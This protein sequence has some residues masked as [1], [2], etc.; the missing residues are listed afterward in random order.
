[1][2]LSPLDILSISIHW[3]LYL[4]LDF[5]RNTQSMHILCLSQLTV[6][7]GHCMRTV[8]LS[9]PL[10]YSADDRKCTHI[11]NSANISVL[12]ALLKLLNMVFFFVFYGAKELLILAWLTWYESSDLI[13]I[14]IVLDHITK[15][16]DYYYSSSRSAYFSWASSNRL[17]AN[18]L[19]FAPPL[20]KLSLSS[21]VFFLLH[22]GGRCS[23]WKCLSSGTFNSLPVC[24]LM[25]FFCWAMCKTLVV[26]SKFILLLQPLHLVAS[27][28]SAGFCACYA[29]LSHLLALPVLFDR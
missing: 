22:D 11:M 12:V 3:S 5:F 21:I 29:H 14:L 1:M 4:R 16:L 26:S 17:Q 15:V 20:K 7:F 23:K 27:L 10:R 8:L 13:I 2:T 6:L 18:L 28:N 24:L 19:L 25:I 9:L